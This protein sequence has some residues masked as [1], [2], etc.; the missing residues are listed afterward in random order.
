MNANS[1][2]GDGEF[3]PRD[4]GGNDPAPA[5]EMSPLRQVRASSGA[6]TDPSARP[7]LANPNVPAWPGPASAVPGRP[8]ASGEEP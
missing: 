7:A 6:D 5:A 2:S 8:A 3:I 4:H 1:N